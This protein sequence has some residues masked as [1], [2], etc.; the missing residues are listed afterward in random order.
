[1]FGGADNTLSW[2]EL[3]FHCC[4]DDDYHSGL[5]KAFTIQAL[6]LAPGNSQPPRDHALPVAQLGTVLFRG[7]A[8]AA[9][10]PTQQ[11]AVGAIVAALG[12]ATTHVTYEQLVQSDARAH[13]AALPTYRRVDTLRILQLQ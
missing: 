6:L 7:A 9:W 8:P 1:M 4:A 13:V 10:T 12:P 11:T 5:E 3:L 2:S